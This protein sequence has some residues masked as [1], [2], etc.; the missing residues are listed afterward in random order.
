MHFVFIPQLGAEALLQLSL[1]H[2]YV[3][4]PPGNGTPH[5]YEM[6]APMAPPGHPPGM[7]IVHASH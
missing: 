4:H 6:I 3:L 7:G 2:P 1:Q 5:L